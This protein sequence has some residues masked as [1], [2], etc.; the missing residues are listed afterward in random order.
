MKKIYIRRKID[1][2][3]SLL[4]ISPK[5][6]SEWHPTKNGDLKPDQFTSRSGWKIWWKCKDGHEWETIIAN[7]TKGH[8]CPICWKN[9]PKISKPNKLNSLTTKFPHLVKEW[10]PAKN[11]DLTPEQFSF[12][13]NKKVWWKCK[14]GHEWEAS[15]S[16]RSYGYNCPFCSGRN[17]TDSN[18][19]SKNYPKLLKEWHP[20]KNGD[21]TP[22]QFSYGSGK[23]VWWKCKEGHEWE[24]IISNRAS[25]G[26]GCPFCSGR[27][28]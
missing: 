28:K 20:S 12:G 8:N 21:L 22:D 3:K 13:S 11:G 1:P 7:R 14:D 18:S 25:K 24:A 4:V 2:A 6:A 26:S 17:T 9:K 19:L 16:N 5:A 10:H 27:K 15:I 23:K